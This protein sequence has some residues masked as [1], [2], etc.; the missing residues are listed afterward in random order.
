MP[1]GRFGS[2]DEVVHRSGSAGSWWCHLAAHPVQ[3]EGNRADQLA[4]GRYRSHPA[5]CSTHA[6]LLILYVWSLFILCLCVLAGFPRTV[7]QAE[8]LDAVC[9]VDS[10]INLDVPFLTI[11]ERLTSRWVHLPSGRVYNVDFNPPKKPVSPLLM[12]RYLQSCFNITSGNVDIKRKNQEVEHLCSYEN[13]SV[14]CTLVKL[15]CCWAL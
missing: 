7:A 10:V 13:S 3:S 8:A 4:T 15:T 1:L 11:R 6:L 5:H 9:D 12:L 2:S 14:T